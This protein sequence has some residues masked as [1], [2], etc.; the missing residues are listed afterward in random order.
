MHQTSSPQE[1]EALD[2][3]GSCVGHSLRGSVLL[4]QRRGGE[5]SSRGALRAHF[6]SQ[7]PTLWFCVNA[8]HT[9]NKAGETLGG[10]ADQQEIA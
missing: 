3:E 9:G 10:F 1:L 6:S 7:R 2:E 4:R 5:E 8:P